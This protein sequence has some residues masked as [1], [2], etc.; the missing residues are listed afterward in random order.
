MELAAPGFIQN[1]CTPNA[2]AT[3]KEYLIDYAS[4]KIRLAGNRLI[5]TELEKFPDGNTKKELLDKLRLIEEAGSRD[6][7]F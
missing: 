4:P 1:M 2:I 5:A 7:L 6:M 3:L